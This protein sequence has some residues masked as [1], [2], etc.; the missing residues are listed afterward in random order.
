MKKIFL[1]VSFVFISLSSFSQDIVNINGKYFKKGMLYSGIHT[2]FYENNKPKT[3]LT[4]SNG[5]L[6]GTVTTFFENGMKQE[7]RSYK[8]GM[9]DGG[10]W[11]IWTIDGKPLYELHYKMGIKTGTW[12]VYDESGKLV[13]ERTF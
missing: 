5:L 3:V 10:D 13:S 8:N 12:R 11:Y 2:E 4:I 1:I 6:D 7:I 9:K